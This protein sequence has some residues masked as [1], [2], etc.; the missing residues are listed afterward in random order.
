MLQNCRFSLMSD[1]AVNIHGLTLLVVGTINPTEIF[2]AHP[3]GAHEPLPWLL[4]PGDKARR[5]LPGNYAIAGEAPIVAWHLEERADQD[6]CKRVRAFLPRLKDSPACVY[7]LILGAPLNAAPGDAL[8]IPAA[9]APR[10]RISHCEFRDFAGQVRILGSH[11]VIESNLMLR[12]GGIRIEPHYVF[13]REAGWVED[14]VVRNNRLVDTGSR[15]EAYSPWRSELGAISVVARKEDPKSSQLFFNGNRRIVI[16]NNTIDGC[17][18]SGI[19][20]RCATALNTTLHVAARLLQSGRPTGPSHCPNA[21]WRQL[22]PVRRWPRRICRRRSDFL[23]HCVDRQGRQLARW[24]STIAVAGQAR[25][26]TFDVERLLVAAVDQV[27]AAGRVAQHL[28][29]DVGHPPAGKARIAV[30]GGRASGVAGRAP[31]G[32]GLLQERDPQHVGGTA[33]AGPRAVKH[34]FAAGNRQLAVDGHVV[35]RAAGGVGRREIEQ[36]KS[37]QVNR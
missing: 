2:V 14:V 9:N 36:V 18:V 8:D 37:E 6:V 22:Y 25:Q 15:P 30:L 23:Q 28:G 16:E 19:Y 10:F 1:D 4:E 3:Y 7:R 33:V 13:W 32:V 27:V 31:L 24:L 5:L 20:A 35:G 17:P 21:R 11:G 12:T 26:G 34:P 29:I